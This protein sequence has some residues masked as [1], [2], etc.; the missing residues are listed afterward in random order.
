MLVAL[1]AAANVT[2]AQAADDAMM[3]PKLA[4]GWY[5]GGAL[6][7]N[8]TRDAD[9]EGGAI[10]TSADFDWGGA[11]LAAV[12]YDFSSPLRAEAELSYRRNDVDSIG[13]V[14]GS[15]KAKG[16]G[17][18]FNL[19]YDIDTGSAFTPYL[20]AGVGVARVSADSYS[21]VGATSI[22][23]RD[24]SYALQGIAGVAYAFNNR[25]ALTLDYRY[26]TA[27]DANYTTASGVGVDAD[28][29]NH[30]I[31]VGLRFALNPPPPPPPAAKP[32]AQPAPPPPAPAAAPAP[33]PAPARNY[34]VFFDWDKSTLSPEAEAILRDAAGA[35][36]TLKSIRIDA[37]GHADRSGS[38]D[39][40]LK[41]SQRRAVAVRDELVRLGIPVG[42][43]AIFAKGETDPLIP[44]P[45]GVRE[46]QNRR[47]QIVLN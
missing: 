3:G 24:T 35:A 7:V 22:D 10:N 9:I 5:I 15:G 13:G 41:L 16:L 20:G 21:P 4:D 40:N 26:F 44:T 29:E 25:T 6:G 1:T 38:T 27:P 2:N 47:V 8:Q 46:P 37:T 34:L 23:D 14:S 19:L 28:Y 32:V 12:G 11:G 43:I 39:Y 36:G 42:E 31:M 18:M 33:A 17:L 30:T 45:D